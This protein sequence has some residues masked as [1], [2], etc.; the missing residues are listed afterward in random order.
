MVE[1]PFYPAN[2]FNKQERDW[3]P[4]AID[5]VL[6]THHPERSRV[7]RGGMLIVVYD[8]EIVANVFELLIDTLNMLAE[9]L[10]GFRKPVA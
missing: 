10:E 9:R 2:L 8:A 6:I 3:D 4:W 7:R 5:E 1:T